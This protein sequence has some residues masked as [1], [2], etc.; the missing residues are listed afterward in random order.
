MN[1]FEEGELAGDEFLVE[2][3]YVVRFILVG[4]F[5]AAGGEVGPIRSSRVRP[6]ALANVRGATQAL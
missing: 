4:D 2:E 1:A 5:V 6:S 3:F